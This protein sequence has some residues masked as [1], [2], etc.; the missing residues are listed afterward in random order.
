MATRFAENLPRI[1]VASDR[2]RAR[3]SRDLRHLPGPKG[4]W[5]WG[6]SRDFLPNPGFFIRRMR[7]RYGDCFTIGVLRNRRQ[8]IL[9]GPRANRLV[10]L[11]P[12]D[13]FSTRWGWEVVH[14]YFPG[15]VLLR[16]FADHRQHRRVMTPLFKPAALR[17]YLDQMDPIIRESLE[18]WRGNVDLYRTQKQLTLDIALRVFGGFKPGPIS[19]AL[20][21]DLSTVLDNVLALPGVRRWRGL[22]ARDRL[23][24]ALRAEL[25]VRREGDGGDLFSRLATQRD[26]SGRRLSDADVVDHMLGLLF[27]AHDTTASALTTICM[28]LAR[29][30]DWQARLRQ[31]CQALREDTGREGL[32]Y[33]LL[34]RLPLTEAFFKE[35]LRQYNPLQIVPRRSVREFVFEDHRIPANAPILLFPQAT[36][37]DPEF[38]PEPERFDPMRFTDSVLQEPFAFIPFGKGSHMCLGMHFA[39]MEV[40]A[41]LYRLLLSREVRFA[42][43][44]NRALN[45]VPIVRPF[46]P[47]RLHLV[48]SAKTTP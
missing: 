20:N 34:D 18:T 25:E 30:P 8:V 26:D 43:C 12:E 29:S 44:G 40:K 31:E 2:L 33:E 16:D 15:M 14:A 24:A 45:Y 27:A 38:F 37:F 42:D 28:Q 9:V 10:L 22:R 39:A 11:D 7:E 41:V 17:Q 23:R 4:H 47:V 19:A 5:F 32:T 6:N 1:P 21:R 36:H 48:P 3:A 46:K 35:T 13:N